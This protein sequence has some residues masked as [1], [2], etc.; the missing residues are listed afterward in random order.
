MPAS[1]ILLPLAIPVAFV[2]IIIGIAN[3]GRSALRIDPTSGA[4]EIHFDFPINKKARGFSLAFF[5]FLNSDNPFSSTPKGFLTRSVSAHESGHTL[6]TS[7]FGGVFLLVNGLDE[8]VLQPTSERG[9]LSLGELYSESRAPGTRRVA[10]F[11]D[12]INS[13]LPIWSS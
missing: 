4:F 13:Y 1:W 2:S 3:H 7:V 10:N 12:A 6:N 11:P 8:V 5:T 9:K